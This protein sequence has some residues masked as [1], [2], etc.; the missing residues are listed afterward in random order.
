ML[1]LVF[2]VER[3]VNAKLLKFALQSVL[4]FVGNRTAL[5]AIRLKKFAFAW[6]ETGDDPRDFLTM[7]ARGVLLHRV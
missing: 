7:D 3:D 4:F 6:R 2:P 5:A 1:V